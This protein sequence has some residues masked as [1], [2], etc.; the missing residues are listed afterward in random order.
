MGFVFKIIS[1]TSFITLHILHNKIHFKI[2]LLINT[3]PTGVKYYK[4]TNLQTIIKQNT[5]NI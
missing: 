5:K 4:T 2:I 3:H 1:N